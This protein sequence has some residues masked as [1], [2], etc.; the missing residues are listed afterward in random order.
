LLEHGRMVLEI[1]GWV[2][3]ANRREVDVLMM[4]ET[5][6]SGDL[7]L[8]RELDGYRILTPERRCMQKQS[9][10]PMKESG[11]VGMLV[12]KELYRTHV[13]ESVQVPW[14]ECDGE[15]QMVR[16]NRGPREQAGRSRL[17]GDPPGDSI[18]ALKVSVGGAVDG[19]RSP[20]PPT[21][22]VAVYFRPSWTNT[23]EA[24]TPNET[25]LRALMLLL[26]EHVDC[27]V[28]IGGDFNVEIGAGGQ[29][30]RV[31]AFKM[32]REHGMAAA[33]GSCRDSTAEHERDTRIGR[34]RQRSSVLDYFLVPEELV[35]RADGSLETVPSSRMLRFFVGAEDPTESDHRPLVLDWFMGVS[36]QAGQAAVAPVAELQGVRP[37]A[38]LLHMVP[39]D[40]TWKP[41]VPG[42][43]PFPCWS[44]NTE[45]GG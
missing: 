36:H 7:M 43:V 12:R 19:A 13:V 23:C 33:N 45:G 8:Q 26:E 14:R 3:G 44:L 11:G 21:L 25:T 10:T 31:T 2:G 5:G 34:A 30:R 37:E 24:G 41:R 40:M 42:E 4:G 15:E 32:I 17:R 39:L 1:A 38:P 9:D 35:P 27:D 20:V 22:L 29:N 28:V 16:E 18:M 6:W